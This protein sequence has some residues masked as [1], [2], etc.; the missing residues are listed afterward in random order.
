MTV[1]STHPL[2][3]ISRLRWKPDGTLAETRFRLLAKRMSTFKSAGALV[4]STTGIRGVRISGSN[5]G[6]AMFRGSVKSTGYPPHSP[7]SSSLPLPCV[8]V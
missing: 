5:A 1:G 8:T 3:E 6:Y 7:V 4:Q 2:T